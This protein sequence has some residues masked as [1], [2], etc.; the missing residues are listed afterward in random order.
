[1]VDEAQGYTDT[2]NINNIISDF[3]INVKWKAFLNSSLVWNDKI[4][5]IK[6]SVLKR[7]H[8]DFEIVIK[9]RIRSKAEDRDV[10]IRECRV[11]IKSLHSKAKKEIQNL[12]NFNGEVW[13]KMDN[14]LLFEYNK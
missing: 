10:K 8:S 7:R 1:M 12:N 5:V 6:W 2:I 4:G 14:I 3:F 11:V 13:D 9:D